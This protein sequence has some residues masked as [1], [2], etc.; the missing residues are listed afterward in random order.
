MLENFE[1]PFFFPQFEDEVFWRYIDRLWDFIGPHHFYSEVE[2]CFVIYGGA[3]PVTKLVLEY[4][5]NYQFERLT[6][7]E[8][9]NV[10]MQYAS[11]TYDDEMKFHVDPTLANYTTHSTYN[12]I[13]QPSYY[14]SNCYTYDHDVSLCP[15]NGSYMHAYNSSPQFDMDNLLPEPS[16]DIAELMALMKDFQESQKI[17]QL[18]MKEFQESFQLQV[19]DIVESQ[20]CLQQRLNSLQLSNEQNMFN[21]DDYNDGWFESKC[22][23]YVGSNEDD[24]SEM[25]EE[26]M[27]IHENVN[28]LVEKSLV[29]ESTNN[30]DLLA[31]H[32]LEEV[33]VVESK[34]VSDTIKVEPAP[35]S[36]HNSFPMLDMV[37]PL[38]MIY[39]GGNVYGHLVKSILSNE[40]LTGSCKFSSLSSNFPFSFDFSFDFLFCKS[41]F[42]FELI[43]VLVPMPYVVLHNM[44]A[45]EFDKLLRAL[46]SSD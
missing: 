40:E 43:K 20:R 38:T 32:S 25:M 7:K 11:E 44:F 34:V 35:L 2:L 46:N 19:S 30:L 21:D 1:I 13:S 39:S 42:P 23:N 33:V 5:C 27:S 4:K 6:P 14:C 3:R 37:P 41:N 16:N 36:F 45:G 24:R 12:D 31:T 17:Y 10:I 8:G 29:E 9:L 22:S 18:Q 28:P 15:H 26:C